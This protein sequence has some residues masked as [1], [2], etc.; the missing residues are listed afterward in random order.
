MRAPTRTRGGRPLRRAPT[1]R[2]GR[3]LPN[4]PRGLTARRL[5]EIKRLLNGSP[6]AAG[7]AA[8]RWSRARI[9]RVLRTQIGVTWA[10]AHA[11][12]VL[13]AH[14]VVISI[15]RAR[16]PRLS[17]AKRRALRRLLAREPE[18][19][20]T[21]SPG[22]TRARIAR[23]IE[24]RFGVRYSL[25]HIGRLLRELHTPIALARR[26]PRLSAAQAAQLRELLSTDPNIGRLPCAAA[27]E[28]IAGTIR[29]RFG[30]TYSAHSIA[31]VL[32]RWMITLPVT[33]GRRR[34]RLAES[35]RSELAEA[36]ARAPSEC[37]LG[38]SRWT[39]Q[40]IAQ[41]IQSRFGLCYRAYNVHRLLARQG[42]SVT[43]RARRGGVCLLNDDQ[44]RTLREALGQAPR[45][46]GL[47]ARRWTRN[48]VVEFIQQRFGS[49]YAAIS[50]SG[51]LR[52]HGL[53]LRK[54]RAAIEP[55]T[56][57]SPTRPDL[58]PAAEAAA[59]SDHIAQRVV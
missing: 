16:E 1:R 11:V 25:Q 45:E 34:G 29:E 51:L 52:R 13:R 24:E 36:L 57:T 35:Q 14:G 18:P 46:A 53:Q 23:L 6:R 59:L 33:R 22:W 37:G 47:A 49:K 40:L 9:A 42:L 50:I 32:R 48:S 39:Q 41:F 19:C 17:T 43:H 8:D 15:P 28:R 21:N 4:R 27:R 56:V 20:E 2:P 12:R 54:P 5:R 55:R 26:E 30:I 31:Q 38:A 44:L 10:G 3:S 58:P 7:I